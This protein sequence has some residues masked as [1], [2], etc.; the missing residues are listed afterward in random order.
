[1]CVTE[2]ARKWLLSAAPAVIQPQLLKPMVHFQEHREAGR[3]R[4]L[5]RAEF[6]WEAE[7]ESPWSQPLR[8]QRPWPFGHMCI[9]ERGDVGTVLII[10]SCTHSCIHSRDWALTGYQTLFWALEMER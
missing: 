7:G 10:H 2:R 4:S 6:E 5:V 9:S 3:G 8:G 1:M